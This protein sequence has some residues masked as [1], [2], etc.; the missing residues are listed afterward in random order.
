MRT[1]GL[2]NSFVDMKEGRLPICSEIHE[3][4][5]WGSPWRCLSH[6]KVLLVPLDV[7]VYRC[8]TDSVIVSQSVF[9]DQENSL[10]A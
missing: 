9:R 6:L 4:R 8:D 2:S 7:P 1:K 5:V 3:F 10:G